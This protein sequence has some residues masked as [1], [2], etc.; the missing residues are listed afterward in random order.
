VRKPRRETINDTGLFHKMWRGHNREPVFE[1]PDDKLSYVR[2][3]GKTYTPEIR[4]RVEW[5]SI[6]L[7][8]NHTH[9]CGRAKLVPDA[10]AGIEPL[11]HWMRNAH[12]RFGAAF[13][14]K[15]HRQGKVA[16]DRPKTTEVEDAEAVLQVMFYGDANPVRAGMVSHPSRYR[17][18]SYGLYACGTRSELTEDLTPPPAY[19][20]LGDT[21]EERQR[22]YRE[23]CDLYLRKQGLINDRPD[24]DVAEPLATDGLE[25]GSARPGIDPQVGRHPRPPG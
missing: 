1:D 18:S 11:S 17:Y 14:R 19:L 16:Y 13:N 3:L 25:T 10:G 23:L 15:H 12:S 22:R 5:Y 24:E 2:S 20:A 7:M 4:E 8:T 21:A 9:E 6:C